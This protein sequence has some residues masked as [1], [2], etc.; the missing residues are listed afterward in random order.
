MRLECLFVNPL[1]LIIDNFPEAEAVECESAKHPQKPELGKRVLPFS[2][3]LWIEQEDFMEVPSKGYFRLSP[4]K[5]IRLRSGFVVKRTDSDK[6]GAGK[7]IAVHCDYY[8]DSK[9]GTPGSDNYKVK[10]NIRWVA[11]GP[12]L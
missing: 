3:E 10:G 5:E 7:V 1:K 12:C 11:A 6:D 2:R 9:S 8:S 4:G